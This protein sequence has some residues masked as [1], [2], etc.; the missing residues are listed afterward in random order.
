[1]RRARTIP[2]RVFFSPPIS[3]AADADS[4]CKVSFPSGPPFHQSPDVKRVVNHP[5]LPPD[6]G[7]P[8]ERVPGFRAFNLIG[9]NR[10]TRSARC[11]IPWPPCSV[12]LGEKCRASRFIPEILFFSP[13]PPPCCLSDLNLKIAHARHVLLACRSHPVVLSP[14]VQPCSG[15]LS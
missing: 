2:R 14:L 5:R 6:P 11:S 12:C 15:P 8:S 9:P 10:T 7:Q 13:L 4:G 3:S 1:L